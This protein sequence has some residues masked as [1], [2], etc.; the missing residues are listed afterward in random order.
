M[1]LHDFQ[2]FWTIGVY[3]ERS[4]AVCVWG[5][6]SQTDPDEVCDEDQNRNITA[7]W[8]LQRWQKL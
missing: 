6:H 8:Y 3:P 7:V 5:K 4:M 2:T 1:V